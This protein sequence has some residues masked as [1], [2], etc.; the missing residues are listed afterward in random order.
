M[1]IDETEVPNGTVETQDDSISRPDELSR[2][3]AD[4]FRL[5]LDSPLFHRDPGM[6]AAQAPQLREL[7]WEHVVRPPHQP[8]EADLA[9][10]DAGAFAERNTDNAAPSIESLLVQARE[11][12]EPVVFVEQLRPVSF[13]EVRDTHDLLEDHDS[14]PHRTQEP[15]LEL[16]QEPQ[17]EPQQESLR[18]SLREA[19]LLAEPEPLP[20][21][22]TLAES[23]RLASLSSTF[24]D[25]KGLS[26]AEFD[27]LTL[28]PEWT[29]VGSLPTMTEEPTADAGPGSSQ[30]RIES[31]FAALELMD[32][33]D[34]QA[35]AEVTQS[36]SA[37]TATHEAAAVAYVERSVAA[38]IEIADE[39][40]AGPAPAPARRA[41]PVSAVEAEL[42]RLAFLPDQDEMAG[43]V[44]VPAIAHSDQREQPPSPALSQ[45]EMYS[46]RQSA[47]IVHHRASPV[48]FAPAYVASRRKPKK[49]V[50]GRL[51]KLVVVLAILAGGVLAAKYYLLDQRW[52]DDVAPLV[53]EVEE[54]RGLSFDHAVAVATL[55]VD[56][57]ASKLATL[58]LGITDDNTAS[59]AG[60]WRALG[61]LNGSLAEGLIGMAA[62]PDSP[63]F[64]D[65]SSET[66]FVAEDLPPELHTFG[67]HRALTLALLD[68][69]YDWSARTEDVSPSVARGTRAYYDADAVATAAGLADAAENTSEV[70]MQ[71][72]GLYGTYQIA[73]SPSP[74]ATT[75]AGRLGVAGRPYI[76][77]LTAAELASGAEERL[78][79]DGQLLDVRRLVTGVAE[80]PAAQSRG[81]LFWYHV[82]ASRIDDNTAWDAALAWRADDVSTTGTTAA[83]AGTCVAA[84]LQVAPESVGIVLAAL[85]GWAA[86]APPESGT[87][88]ALAPGGTP[89]QIDVTACD[90]GPGVPT[91]DGRGHLALGGAPL[92]AEQYRLLVEADPALPP[93]QAA[94]AVFGGDPVSLADER[95][96][97]DNVEGWQA[98]ANHPAPDPNRLGC[99]PT[100]A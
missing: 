35:A 26:A 8:V 1:A 88:V 47:P 10:L 81:M 34:Q 95:G 5:R 80:S 68:Q 86:A 12:V 33:A 3:P 9:S 96:M 92:R 38:P 23:P 37:G 57:Y 32:H 72:Y 73:A 77:S 76:E 97:V 67:M 41:E 22:P 70:F 14:V 74:F 69:Q 89:M 82:L 84:H 78:I 90:P 45:H 6:S 20:V 31:L 29:S 50:L 58:S 71:I 55:P 63:A 75:V 49:S 2:Y 39:P 79:S 13:G 4:D 83:A 62:L 91:N 16:R 19:E 51:V 98:P 59:I 99:A 93:A 56:E 28:E 65:P 36:E 66:I 46:P 40:V 42:N 25:D 52:D 94:C 85:Q 7:T 43:P 18:E 61:L 53:A 17:Q 15:H 48:D 24:A 11:S 100:P 27:A 87:T 30:P 64:Y 21:L 60:E 54:A 44:A